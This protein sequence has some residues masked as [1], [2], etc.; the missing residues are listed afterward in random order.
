MLFSMPEDE[1]T[2]ADS[3]SDEEREYSFP[4]DCDKREKRAFVYAAEATAGAYVQTCSERGC[5]DER[6]DRRF[7]RIRIFER[8]RL[9]EGKTR[10]TM[11]P[12]TCSFTSKKYSSWSSW[13]CSFY[14]RTLTM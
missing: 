8:R 5:D 13:R 1:M 11:D 10:E 3:P 12:G 9:E 7:F 2:E 6:K 4:K 14:V